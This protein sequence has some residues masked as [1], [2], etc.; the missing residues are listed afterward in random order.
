MCRKD[1]PRDRYYGGCLF[2]N[3]LEKVTTNRTK[4]LIKCKHANVQTHSGSQ[5]NQT[6]MLLLLSLK[7]AIMGMDLK[8]GGH[9]I[10]GSTVE[11]IR[12]VI[13]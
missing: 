12:N 11:Y 13:Q 4:R 3:E 8:C 10:H 1:Y 6:V 7:D 2:T 5:T 9:L